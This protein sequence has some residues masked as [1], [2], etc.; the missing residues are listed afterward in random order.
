M[1]FRCQQVVQQSNQTEEHVEMKAKK[2]EKMGKALPIGPPHRRLRVVLLF[3]EPWP[4]HA[5]TLLR[6]PNALMVQFFI[7]SPT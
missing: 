4:K 6:H 7:Q 2:Q 5:R 3:P 1:V